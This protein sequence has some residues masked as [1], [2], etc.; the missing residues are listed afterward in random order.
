[1]DFRGFVKILTYSEKKIKK[2]TGVFRSPLL[3]LAYRSCFFA[4]PVK[5]YLLDA[6]PSGFPFYLSFGEVGTAFFLQFRVR[7]LLFSEFG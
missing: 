7:N 1:L 5:E 6:F 3:T 4:V 2:L